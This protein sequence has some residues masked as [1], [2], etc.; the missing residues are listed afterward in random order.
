MRIASPELPIVVL[1][2]LSDLATATAALKAGASD[3]LDK[4]DLRPRT[5]LRAIRYAI[6]RK[7]AE[8]ELMR[9]ARTDSLTGLLNR[10][11]FFEQLEAALVQTRRS[12][13]ACAV[14]LFDIDRFKEINDLFGH[15]TGDDLLM[16]VA[17]V[18]RRSCA[19]PTAI[20]RIGGDEFAVL[21]TNLKSAAAA[22]EIAEKIAKGIAAISELDDVRVDDHRS[23]SAFRS[24]RSTIPPPTSWSPTPTWRCTSRRRARRARSTSST[25]AWMPP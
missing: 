18:L 25:P 17:D 12:E 9:L 8:A 11:A 13:L 21:A 19:R 10:R 4:A 2:G 3:Y 16:A 15:K 22:M 23:A 6:E 7:K 5:L 24:S 14:I 20:G 1:T